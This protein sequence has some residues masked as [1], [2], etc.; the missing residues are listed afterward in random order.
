MKKIS[1]LAISLLVLGQLL[2]FNCPVTPANDLPE[3]YQSIDGTSGKELLDAIQQVAKLGYRTTDFRYDSVWL[4]FKYTD[5]RPDG[6]V[7]EIYSDCQFEYEKDRTSNT[8]QTG[9]CKGY[10]REHAMCQSWFSEYDLQGNKMSSSKKNSPG[11]DIFHIYPTSYGM[12]SRRGNRPYGEVASA[13]FTSGNGTEY[14]APVSSLSVENSV[15]GVYVEGSINMSTNVLEPADEYKGDIARSSFGTMVKWAGEWAFN[16][17]DLGRVIFD[18]TIDADTHYGPENN[19]GLTDYGLALLLTWHRQDPVSQKEVDRN[20]GIQ[21]TQG[22][23]NP[24]IDYPYLVEYIWGEMSG[25]ILE[26]DELLCSADELF[27]LGVS[28]GYLG[29]VTDKQV[30]TVL[31]LVGDMQYELSLVNHGGRLKYLPKAPASCSEVSTRFMGW[32]DM[33]IAGSIHAAPEVLYTQAADFPTVNGNVVY[34][35]V[36]AEE[37]LSDMMGETITIN[38]SDSTDWTL[39]NLK[40]KQNKTDGAYWILAKDA[41]IISPVIDLQALDSVSMNIRSYQSRTT[42]SISVDGEEIGSVMAT[43]NTIQRYVWIA[44]ELSGNKPLTFTGIDATASYGVGVN[45]ISLYMGGAEAIY[46]NYLT[47]CD[48]ISSDISSTQMP[49]QPIR[50]ILSNGQLYI[51][52]NQQTYD[53]MGRVVNR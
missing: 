17:V 46:V 51:Q 31:W 4:A 9:E 43:T 5:L 29:E 18:A 40:H 41:S 19:Y 14:G 49:K 26:M 45:E 44:P 10:N 11:S 32:T 16:R 15:A 21:L 27:E 20:N 3:Y 7:W 1:L 35:A 42:V 34:Y 24:F 30:D 38:K 2:A 25:E 48:D 52:V 8:E 28:N 47:H 50:K 13:Q 36:F 23:R 12:N 39:Q 37:I 22:N 53:S 6:L 33:P